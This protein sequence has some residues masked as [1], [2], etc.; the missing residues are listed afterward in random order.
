MRFLTMLFRASGLVRASGWLGLSAIA[1]LL[2]PASVWAAACMPA[3]A[4][5]KPSPPNIHLASFRSAAAATDDQVGITFIGHAT[6]LIESPGGVSLV[7][8]YNN[9]F[10]PPGMPDVITMNHAHS[11]HYTDRVDPAIKLVLRGWEPGGGIA[12]RN[13]TFGDVK[14]G[15]VQTNIRQFYGGAFDSGNT[16]GGTEFGGNS[17]FTFEIAQLCIAHLSHL[18]HTLTPEHI[19]ELGQVDVLM[20]PVDGTYTMSHADMLDVIDQIKPTLVIPMHYFG[21]TVLQ[22]FLAKARDRYPV[23]SNPAPQVFLSRADLPR[24]TEILVFPGY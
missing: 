23:R 18:H 19:A 21:Q 1:T 12:D 2:M 22:T 5:L 7:T 20:A 17:I 3:V 16:G 14:I 8:D 24:T 9:Y 13:V 15:N 11:T 10:R 4:S 6:F